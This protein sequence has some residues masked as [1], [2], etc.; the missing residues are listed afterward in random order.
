MTKATPLGSLYIRGLSIFLSNGTFGFSG[1]ITQPGYYQPMS[2]GI[3]GPI[4]GWGYTDD[5]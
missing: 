1:Y 4:K 3:E 5:H 2:I